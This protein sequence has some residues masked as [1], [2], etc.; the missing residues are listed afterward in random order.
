MTATATKLTALLISRNATERR[1]IVSSGIPSRWRIQAPSATP[2]APLAGTSD[3]TAS[4]ASAIS[5][6]VRRDIRGQ[7]TGR[8][9][10]T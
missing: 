6:L 3:P 9:I 5:E 2:L 8:N 7:K 10:S 4:S 1:A